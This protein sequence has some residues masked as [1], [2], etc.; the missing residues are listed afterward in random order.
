MES[1][2]LLIHCSFFPQSLLRILASISRKWNSRRMFQ[3]SSAVGLEWNTGEQMD[4]A[5][6]GVGQS[7][8][9]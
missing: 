5:E 9:V 2:Y 6:V 7:G 1:R 3:V 8:C 4:A